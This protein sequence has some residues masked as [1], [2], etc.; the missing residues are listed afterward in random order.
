MRPDDAPLSLTVT[1]GP[2]SSSRI[3]DA[4]DSEPF[5]AMNYALGARDA[6]KKFEEGYVRGDSCQVSQSTSGRRRKAHRGVGPAD[7]R[8][9]G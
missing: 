1:A 3:A 7:V 5:A 6:R 9:N 8:A 2:V 4:L